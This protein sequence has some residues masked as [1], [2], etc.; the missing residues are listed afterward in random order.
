M[1]GIPDLACDCWVSNSRDGR[2]VGDEWFGQRQ[3]LLL[4]LVVVEAMEVTRDSRDVE[5]GKGTAR[6]LV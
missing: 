4:W 1:N 5:K 3:R 6:W 2:Q